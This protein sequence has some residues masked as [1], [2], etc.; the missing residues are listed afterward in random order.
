MGWVHTMSIMDDCGTGGLHH[1]KDG[2]E[3]V[4]NASTR[5]NLPTD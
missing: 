4:L 5:D 3:F 1:E 2:R